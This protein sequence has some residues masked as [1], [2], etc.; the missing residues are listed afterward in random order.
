[1]KNIDKIKK[2][3]RIL[4]LLLI[5][6]IIAYV[7]MIVLPKRNAVNEESDKIKYD[8]VLYKRDNKLYK[9]IFNKL[10]DELDDEIDYDKYAEYIS[11]LFVIDL[12][13]LNNKSSKDDI[14]GLQF[15]YDSF[16]ENFVLNIS[17]TL[18]KY[19]A[20]QNELPEVNSIELISLDKVDYTIN[21]KSYSGYEVSLKWGYVKDYGYDDKGIIIL[22][23]DGEKL[24]V[25]EKK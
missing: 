20:I 9:D 1:M 12:Y 13:T 21:N 19:I 2:F 3:L 15:I 7:I 5:I 23:K 14:G 24:Y 6:A 18:Y 4:M 17:N 25:V 8:Y 10:K 11:E 22:I 16:K